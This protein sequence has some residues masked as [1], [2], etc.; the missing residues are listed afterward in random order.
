MHRLQNCRMN[1]E[2]LGSFWYGLQFAVFDSLQ[3]FAISKVCHGF[4]VFIDYTLHN[5]QFVLVHLWI[6]FQSCSCLKLLL[7][8][9]PF[10]S[11]KSTF[12][13]NLSPDEESFSFQAGSSRKYSRGSDGNIKSD[14]SQNIY[15]RKYKT[16]RK[17]YNNFFGREQIG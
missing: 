13:L 12:P 17:K 1:N 6:I 2:M 7:L 15:G 8:R 5:L 10:R 3:S 16:V 14:F 11:W 4:A 9:F